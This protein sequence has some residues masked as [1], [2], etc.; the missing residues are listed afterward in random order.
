MR[1]DLNLARRPFVNI[2]LPVVLAAVTVFGI[3]VFSA[4]NLMVLFSEPAEG[5]NF[6]D[7]IEQALGNQERMREEISKI[8]NFIEEED[9]ARLAARIE[10]AN[11]LIQK[12]KLNW[13]LLFDRLEEL[14]PAHV[15]M[16][17]ISPRV[18]GEL[19][20]LDLHVDESEP[21]A[22][23]SYTSAL[24]RSPHFSNVLLVSESPSSQ[25]AGQRWQLEATYRNE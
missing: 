19:I 14:T 24:R 2:T 15:R 8:R 1:Y 13:T 12:R 21:G 3:L 17:R 4:F 10:F 11:E 7:E 25:G 20:V 23:L 6:K 22:V 18:E 16:L 5:G 9:L